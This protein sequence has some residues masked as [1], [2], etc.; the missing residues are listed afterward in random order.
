MRRPWIP[1]ASLALLALPAAAQASPPEPV[2]VLEWPD[3]ARQVRRLVELELASIAP[4]GAAFLRI[5]GLESPPGPAPGLT[6]L[7]TLARGDRLRAEVLG[8]SGELLE[9]GLVGSAR[10]ALLVDSLRGLVF[11]GRVQ[12][13]ARAGLTPPDSGDLLFWLRP[14]ETIDRVPGT[15]VAFED[16]GPRLQGA[17]GERVFPWG[18]VAALFIEPLGAPPSPEPGASEPGLRPDASVVVDL[19]DGGRLSGRL[20]SLGAGG[21]RL[22]HAPGR[23]VDLPL[24]ALSEVLADDGR[25]RFLSDLEPARVAEGSPF[26]DDLGLTWPHRRDASVT[27]APLRAGGRTW[28]RGLGVH[29]PSRLAYALDGRW[30]SLRGSVAVDDQVLLLSAR[31]SVE[32]RVLVD[33]ETRWSSGT[34]RGGQPPLDL[35]AVDLSDAQE[36]ELV[37]DMAEDHYVADRAD[38]LRLLLVRAP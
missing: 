12:P 36:L 16:E 27:G 19:V 38:W 22:E 15:L 28:S 32:F 18:E 1:F 31:G 11:E 6:A 25:V 26:D 5:E 13:Q 33:G 9:L 7:A 20:L 23:E 8:G 2:A 37:V 35:P 29:A 17:F 30:S 10:L 3:G 21:L 4:E 34:V 24:A 14:G